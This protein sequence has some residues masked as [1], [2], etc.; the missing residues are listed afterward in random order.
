V[1]QFFFASSVH[2]KRKK[3]M[4]SS[5]KK[6]AI[7]VNRAENASPGSYSLLR[8]LLS[9]ANFTASGEQDQGIPF[10]GPNPVEGDESAVAK[11]P[12]LDSAEFPKYVGTAGLRPESLKNIGQR[13]RSSASN[14]PAVNLRRGDSEISIWLMIAQ[15][16]GKDN[17][18]ARN[19]GA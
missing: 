15:G 18:M 11:T 17:E 5:P 19:V 4:S 6:P 13:R 7:P 16:Y 2:C 3:N 12:E 10:T 9:H 14:Q 8:T 1:D